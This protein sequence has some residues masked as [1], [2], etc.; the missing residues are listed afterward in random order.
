MPVLVKYV[1]SGV[2]PAD[3]EALKP[4][5]NWEG[6]PPEGGLFHMIWFAKGAVHEIDVWEDRASFDRFVADRFRPALAK[7][8]LKAR[9]PEVLDLYNISASDE[10]VRHIPRTPKSPASTAPSAGLQA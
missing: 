1:Q 2:G 6:D 10:I 4:I 5:V 7:Y 8:G 3:Y 9:S